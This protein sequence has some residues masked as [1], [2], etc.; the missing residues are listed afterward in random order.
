MFIRILILKKKNLQELVETSNSLFRNL[1]KN[2]CIKEEEPK[3]HKRLFD[4]PGPT[5]ISNCGTPLRVVVRPPPPSGI[6]VPAH[7]LKLVMKQ[8]RSNT[9]DSGNFIKKFKEIKEVPKDAVIVT[10]DVVAVSIQVFLLMLGWRL[11]GERLMI[12]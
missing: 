9:I 2:G 8:S 1:K 3:I 11:Q 10:V 7:V 12:E 6:V 4:F 5:V